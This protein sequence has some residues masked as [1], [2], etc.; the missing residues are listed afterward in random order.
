MPSQRWNLLPAQKLTA[1]PIHQQ[2][3]AYAEAYL[4]SAA[5]LCTTLARSSRKAS[6]ERG[7][8]VLYLTQHG[9]ELFYKGAILKSAPKERFSHGLLHLQNRYKT[10]YPAKRYNVKELFRASYEGLTK[11]Q[12]SQVQ[13]LEPPVDQLFR[14]PE[15]KT[16]NSWQGLF[17]FEASS[18]RRELHSLLE[19][20]QSARKHI[21]A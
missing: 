10:L 19:Q 8:V 13:G 20:V 18:F 17:A 16:G 2:Y 6:F 12:I 9:L 14:Y 7:A 4:D 3:F 1:L 15:D 21:D 11:A 5:R